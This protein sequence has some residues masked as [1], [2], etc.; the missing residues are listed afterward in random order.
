M[1]GDQTVPDPSPLPRD[2]FMCIRGFLVSFAVLALSTGFSLSPVHA[3]GTGALG[4]ADTF[5]FEYARPGEATILVNVWGNVARAGL[6]RVERDVDL[7][8]FLSVVEVPGVGT[9]R[10]GT[11]S[12]NVVTVYRQ[13][14]GERTVVYRRNL[15]DI[16]EDGVQYP[17]LENR[18]VL[19]IET[20][21]RQRIGF[22]L[23]STIISTVSSTA[24]LIL[25]LTRNR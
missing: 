14:E 22:R 25:L 1:S 11:R 20:T 3:Q 16:L 13:R 24:S 18:D 12:R 2:V 21:Q 10:I 17:R 8:E 4:D 15:E 6:W 9:N 5:V 19:E 7:V 23:V